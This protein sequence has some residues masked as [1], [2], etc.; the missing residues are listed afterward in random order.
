MNR[1]AALSFL[2]LCFPALCGK[3]HAEDR[4]WHFGVE[5][6]MTGTSYTHRHGYYLTEDYYLAESTQAGY[7]LHLNG[8]L[9][10]LAGW[11]PLPRA[12]VSLFAGT[13]GLMDDVQ[14]F[15]VGLRIERLPM[16]GER[17]SLLYL[18]GAYAWDRERTHKDGRFLRAGYGYRIPLGLGLRL[19]LRTALRV[20]WAHPDLYDKYGDRTVPPDLLR[21]SDAWG[22]GLDFSVTISF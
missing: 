12:G 19:D 8:D 4:T 6:G 20:A 14:A 3:V 13:C 9:L 16:T 2:I 22:M 10:L 17:G 11:H 18:D 1:L 5:W 15:P 21:S 7:G